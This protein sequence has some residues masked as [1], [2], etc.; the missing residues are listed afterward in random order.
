MLSTS[1]PRF[2]KSLKKNNNREWFEANKKEFL[3]AKAEF[4]TF[5]DA[6]IMKI[7]KHDPSVADKQA[8][9]CIFRIYRDVRFSKDKS[10]Y[11]NHFGAYIT[12]AQSKSEVSSK[13]GYY[14]HL[15]PGG[16]F[17]AGGAYTPEAPWLKAIRQEIDYNTAEFKK[18]LNSASFKKYFGKMEGEQLVNAPKEYP[19]DH[20][21]I[22][23][24]KHKSFLAVHQL[25]DK[26]LT[27]E[28]FL[29]HAA[30]A[31]KAMQPFNQFLNRAM[32]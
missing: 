21:E 18:I 14:I 22:G 5:V 31:F 11:K 6:L 29:N 7:G 30:A 20:P 17:L 2:L 27:S 1:T 15:E 8:K 3:S 32:D 23:L 9:N 25:D 24:L 10:P 13:A 12:S 4:E 26:M 28:Q 16:A 19:K